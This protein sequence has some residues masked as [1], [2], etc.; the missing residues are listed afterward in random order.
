MSRLR[1]V[2]LVRSDAYSPW[3]Q[4]Q[5]A[6]GA[7]AG[8]VRRW[9][10]I[11]VVLGPI[12]CWGAKSWSAWLFGEQVQARTHDVGWMAGSGVG[13]PRLGDHYIP[14]PATVP[15]TAV[16]RV[17]VDDFNAE[18]FRANFSHRSPVVLTGVVS[19]WPATSRWSWRALTDEAG[20]YG[21]YGKALAEWLPKYF[22]APGRDPA[23]L[24]NETLFSDG[25]ITQAPFSTECLVAQVTDQDGGESGILGGNFLPRL[26]ASWPSAR[27]NAVEAGLLLPA[28][29]GNSGDKACPLSHTYLI[30]GP[31]GAGGTLHQDPDS[32]AYWNA[33]VHG[34]KRWMFIEPAELH[35]LASALVLDP[36]LRSNVLRLA[37]GGPA[38]AASWTGSARMM[39]DVLQTIPAIR[40]FGTLMPLLEKSNVMF[41]HQDVIVEAGELIYGPPNLLH[42][43]LALEDSIGCSEQIV[44][45]GNL[46]DWVRDPHSVYSPEDVHLACMAASM[47]WPELVTPF[48]KLCMRAARE[49]RHLSN[50]LTKG[51]Q[52][53]RERAIVKVGASFG[54]QPV[55]KQPVHSSRDE[56]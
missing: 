33:V 52:K 20:R 7:L 12:P 11:L 2:S 8:H 39:W 48:Q 19:R 56:L 16:P 51:G 24:K 25:L 43:V 45:A 27:D 15:A 38:S 54:R 30:A 46:A 41:Q 42:I 50:T 49:L 32:T 47:N 35:L 55:H 14:S 44:D 22:V 13:R 53:R 26:C 29:D 4:Q 28:K 21:P 3:L 31:A 17:S 34:R 37:E 36:V 18:V 9:W 1:Y 40:W 10:I 6:T 5:E 23:L